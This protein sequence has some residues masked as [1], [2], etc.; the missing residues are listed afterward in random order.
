M[1]G[2]EIIFITL[3]PEGPRGDLSA[4]KSTFAHNSKFYM[5]RTAQNAMQVR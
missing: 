3:K 5:S 4:D 2:K 1:R